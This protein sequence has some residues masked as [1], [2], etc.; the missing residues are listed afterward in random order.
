MV[1][2]CFY[3]CSQS[4]TLVIAFDWIGDY[5][6]LGKLSVINDEKKLL[7]RKSFP[8]VSIM[9]SLNQFRDIP[10]GGIEILSKN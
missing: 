2:A 1:N 9:V 3:L 10:S 7:S 6:R 4:S 5:E 8:N